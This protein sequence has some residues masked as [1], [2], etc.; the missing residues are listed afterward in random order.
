MSSHRCHA[1]LIGALLLLGACTRERAAG[2][3]P[4]AP[5]PP[6]LPL[7]ALPELTRPEPLPA[8]RV[9]HLFH[10]SNVAAEAEPCG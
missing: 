10:T 7:P 6:P 8:R 3:P 9:L 5:E 2:A 4:K 1:A